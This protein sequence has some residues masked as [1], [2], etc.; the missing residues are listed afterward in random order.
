M[1]M[2]N[3]DDRDD[4]GEPLKKHSAEVRSMLERI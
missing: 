1:K 2:A 4:G 3:K